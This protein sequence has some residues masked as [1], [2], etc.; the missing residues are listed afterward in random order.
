V[1]TLEGGK[2]KLSIERKGE[3]TF[4]VLTL[5]SNTTPTLAGRFDGAV[6]ALAYFNGNPAGAAWLEIEP[7]KDARVLSLV[8]QKPGADPIRFRTTR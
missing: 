5:D 1:W 4:A 6:F 2:G 7:D 3:D 8:Y